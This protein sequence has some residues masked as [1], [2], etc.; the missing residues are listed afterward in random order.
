VKTDR[1]VDDPS[2]APIVG[3]VRAV[4]VAR[5]AIVIAVVKAVVVVLAG[6]V[7]A[8]IAAAA[9]EVGVVTEANPTAFVFRTCNLIL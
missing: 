6:T 2:M 9:A 7:I 1:V 8:V 5:A 4:V 3:V